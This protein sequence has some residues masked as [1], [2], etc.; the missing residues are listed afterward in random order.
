MAWAAIRRGWLTVVLTGLLFVIATAYLRQPA[1]EVEPPPPPTPTHIT[2][3]F[4]SWKEVDPLFPRYAC[5]TV[6]D[7]ETGLSFRVQRRAGDHHAD[8]QPLSAQD[9]AIMKKVYSGEWAW[10][11]RAV[12]VALDNGRMVAASMNGM[13]HG[14]GAIRGNNFKGHFCIHFRDSMTHSSRSRDTAHQV[15]VWKAA[16]VL[17]EQLTGLNAEQIIEVALEAIA[18]EDPYILEKVT[19]GEGKELLL[20]GLPTIA[21][22]KTQSLQPIDEL[23]FTATVQLIKRG[24]IKSESR[25]L[26]VEVKQ[27]P[28]HLLVS[29]NSLLPLM[30]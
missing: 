3:E 7:Y 30:Q 25:V 2:G 20:Q 9:T 4:L 12:I 11:R 22:L 1:P 27:A 19:Q 24:N 23:H 28:L 13:P 17:E 15:M 29:S 5:A 16:G 21:W 8:V 14:A 18:H 6:V 10:K 26:N